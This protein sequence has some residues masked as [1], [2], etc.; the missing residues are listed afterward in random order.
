MPYQ[1]NQLQVLAVDDD[2]EMLQLYKIF[3]EQFGYVTTIVSDSKIGLK[4][5]LENPKKY[6]FIIT[7]YQLPGINGAE[8][9]KKILK[10]NPD[11]PIIMVSGFTKSFRKMDALEIG[12]TDCFQKPLSFDDM[13]FI[14]TRMVNAS[15]EQIITKA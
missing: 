8:L 5:F 3:G 13:K 6:Q 12:I 15:P 2:Y 9:S 7:D 1:E 14:W 11:I 10:V 4:L